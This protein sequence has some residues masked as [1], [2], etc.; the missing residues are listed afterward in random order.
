MALANHEAKLCHLWCRVADL[1]DHL[2]I[3]C[4]LLHRN[5]VDSILGLSPYRCFRNNS[6]QKDV[7][8]K[9]TGGSSRSSPGN[10][11]D[12]MQPLPKYHP[13]LRPFD[14]SSETQ[15]WNKQ[16]C[17]NL[18]SVISTR[19]LDDAQKEFVQLQ[20]KKLGER[21]HSSSSRSFVSQI[22]CIWNYI[23]SNMKW[24]E[25]TI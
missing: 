11:S 7:C 5:Y 18:Y 9:H 21:T 22:K 12:N 19:R 10:H 23:P 16:G 14:S 8:G 1:S 24:K 15:R 20:D 25:M 2:Y 13:A 6:P 17:L 4:R 3:C